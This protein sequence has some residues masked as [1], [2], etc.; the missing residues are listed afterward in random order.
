M[1]P[2]NLDIKANNRI[3]ES[4]DEAFQDEVKDFI[5]S[6]GQSDKSSRC[7][8]E[9]WI[10]ERPQVLFFSLN[11]VRYDQELKRPIKCHDRFSFD[12]VIYAD[13]FLYKNMEKANI[14]REEIDNAKAK[15]KKINQELQS[16]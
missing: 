4:W 9:S 12:K 10:L 5:L 11:R 13:M 16:Y 14:V 1:G 3:Y 2:I 15:I 6:G 7:F 8:K